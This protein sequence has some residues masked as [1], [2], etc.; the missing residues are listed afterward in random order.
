[1]KK[2]EADLRHL[3]VWLKCAQ[4]SVAIENG[5]AWMN[6]LKIASP[7]LITDYW[8]RQAQG[9]FGPNVGQVVVRDVGWDRLNVARQQSLILRRSGITPRS[10]STGL[11]IIS[12]DG[13]VW[14]YRILF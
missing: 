10:F 14:T 6:K 13:E 12:V 5:K 7:E 2:Q 4:N 3:S 11:T 1:V 9:T 8:T